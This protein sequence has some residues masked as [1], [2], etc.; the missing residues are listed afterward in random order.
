MNDQVAKTS[1]W[2][3]IFSLYLFIQEQFKLRSV[4]KLFNDSVLAS[5]KNLHVKKTLQKDKEIEVLLRLEV[6]PVILDIRGPYI[7]HKGISM[8]LELGKSQ[9]IRIVDCDNITDQTLQV[10]GKHGQEL[11][12]LNIDFRPL[13]LS[14]RNGYNG[15]RPMQISDT[16]LDAIAQGCPHLKFFFLRWSK[17]IT[18]KSIADLCRN[19]VELENVTLIWAKPGDLVAESLSL[20]ASTLT[21]LDLRACRDFSDDKL[22]LMFEKLINL[23]KLFLYDVPCSNSSLQ[24]IANSCAPNLEQL[25]MSDLELVTD[26][27]INELAEKVSDKLK[28]LH[29]SHLRNITEDSIVKLLTAA[30]SLNKIDIAYIGLSDAAMLRISSDS[31][32]LKL[33]KSAHF[34]GLKEISNEGLIEFVHSCPVLCFIECLNSKA[35]N[36]GL[37]EALKRKN[38]NIVLEAW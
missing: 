25:E 5:L 8:L 14:L 36:T 30:K 12:S 2:Q 34:D 38:L 10:L 22:I 20:R 21:Y 32:A 17:K 23:R 4:C 29:L 11:H 1:V 18:D 7:T 33:L 35:T 27:G 6:Y 37:L 31:S 15:T 3:R 9:N 16:G 19:C 28:I 13:S 24:A 26:N